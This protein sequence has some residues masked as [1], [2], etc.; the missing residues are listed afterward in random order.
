MHALLPATT[1]GKKLLMGATGLIWIAFVVA[2]VAGNLLV[3]RGPSALNG[4]STLLHGS[5]VVL[6][7]GRAV[8]YGALLLHI[9]SGLTLWHVA[10]EARRGAYARKV[11]Q[12]ATVS[13]R[14]IRWT[15][16]A[17]LAFIVF[18]IL[19]LSTGIIRPVP[20][21]RGDVYSNVTRSF[22]VPWVAA[23]YVV[24]MVAVTLHVLHGTYA[25]F[26]SLGWV[27]LRANPFDRRLAIVVALVI[28]VGFTVIPVTIFAGVLG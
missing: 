12:A 9:A 20:Y 6:W 18:H 10:A 28:W 24:A 4:Y 23:V 21:E 22:Q 3:F 17:V 26:K 14:T 15:G 19:H 1:V 27:R 11:P 2:H 16:L 25:S 13:S 7:V 8:I 5:A